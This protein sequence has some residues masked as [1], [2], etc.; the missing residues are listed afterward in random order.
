M[1]YPDEHDIK[2]I[3][4]VTFYETQHLSSDGTPWPDTDDS[5][6]WTG[7]ILD[8][9]GTHI[10]DL[11]VAASTDSTSWIVN[12]SLSATLS[13]AMTQNK[14]KWRVRCKRLSDDWVWELWRGEV[15]VVD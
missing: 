15:I 13:A 1:L 11:V 2:I 6:T 7:E 4:G 14:G 10:D 8:S 5:Y 3:R 9:A 12:Y